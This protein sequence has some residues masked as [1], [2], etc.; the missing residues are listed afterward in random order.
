MYKYRHGIYIYIYTPYVLSI[1]F[2]ASVIIALQH[3]TIV[4]FPCLKGLKMDSNMIP[5]GFS[6][7]L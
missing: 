1:F 5:L 2:N 3:E 6:R 7:V 4:F